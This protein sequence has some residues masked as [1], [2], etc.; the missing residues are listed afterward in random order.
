ME[1]NN[2]DGRANGLGE[3]F[4]TIRQKAKK[5]LY[6]ARALKV[7]A[8]MNSEK[9]LEFLEIFN[10][11]FSVFKG[12]KPIRLGIIIP[13]S[14]ARDRRLLVEG[15]HIECNSTF[16]EEIVDRCNNQEVQQQVLRE[17][18]LLIPPKKN[19]QHEEAP[20]SKYMEQVLQ[21]LAIEET[22]A[23]ALVERVYHL[24][25]SCR[26]TTFVGILYNFSVFIY[27][28]KN[29]IYVEAKIMKGGWY[30]GVHFIH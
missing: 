28:R 16:M 20:Q 18:V 19:L 9:L 17:D 10:K 13:K 23:D 1:K 8:Y 3:S 15:L 29:K 11:E 4:R 22:P 6:W 25:E 26:E 30:Q 2:T 14:P 5:N 24:Y 27:F 12:Y 21:E 7:F